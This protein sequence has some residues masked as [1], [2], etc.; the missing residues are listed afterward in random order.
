[1]AL[2]VM[3]NDYDKKDGKIISRLSF[4]GNISYEELNKISFGRNNE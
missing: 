4:D 1:M 3:D 2:I